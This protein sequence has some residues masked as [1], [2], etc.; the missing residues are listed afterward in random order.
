MGK[1]GVVSLGL[2]GGLIGGDG[3]VT[4]IFFELPVEGF[5][6]NELEYE[7]SYQNELLY[8]GWF[9]LEEEQMI[10]GDYKDELQY[11]GEYVK[12]LEYEGEYIVG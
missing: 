3:D 10:L 9:V 6:I 5:Y 12:E 4:N 11:E 8:E 2:R 7:G 1:L